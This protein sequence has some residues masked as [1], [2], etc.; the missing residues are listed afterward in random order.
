MDLQ[1]SAFVSPSSSCL[2]DAGEREGGREK[3][4]SQNHLSLDG[5]QG[6]TGVHLEHDCVLQSSKVSK[7]RIPAPRHA[8]IRD[9]IFQDNK[10]GEQS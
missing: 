6:G 1:L 5:V 7:N 8:E 9:F 10:A 2:L 4:C 3:L